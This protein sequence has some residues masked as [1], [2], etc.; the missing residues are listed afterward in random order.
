MDR[1]KTPRVPFICEVECAEV[2]SGTRTSNPRMSDLSTTG[3][4]VDSMATFDLGTDVN[5]RFT[6]P[7]LQVSVVAEVVNVI[8]NMGMGLVFRD[9]TPAQEVA[10]QE[11]IRSTTPSAAESSP[12]RL[13]TSDEAERP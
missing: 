2:Q 3:A 1:R 12:I 7:S 13:R 8:P 9:L 6:V 5:L 11:V 10:I 4:F